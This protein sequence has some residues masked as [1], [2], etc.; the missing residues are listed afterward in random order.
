MLKNKMKSKTKKKQKTFQFICFRCF[1]AIWTIVADN[2]TCLRREWAQS[3]KLDRNKR[4]TMIYPFSFLFFPFF[5][6]SILSLDFI[7]FHSFTFFYFFLKQK[8][9]TAWLP[10]TTTSSSISF[11]W[12]WNQHRTQHRNL[13]CLKYL[14]SFFS[15]ES[16][17]AR[18]NPAAAHIKSPDKTWINLINHRIRSNYVALTATSTRPITVEK[19][20]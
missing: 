13:C 20:N 11:Q 15:V 9:T 19:G 18:W 1:I 7:L 12:E 5:F 14:P 16:R 4:T 2:S 17:S 8:T 6:S 10:V 3:I